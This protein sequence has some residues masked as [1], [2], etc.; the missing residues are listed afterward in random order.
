MHHALHLNIMKLKQEYRQPYL[1]PTEPPRP[2]GDLSSLMFTQSGKRQ[3][4]HN[5]RVQMTRFVQKTIRTG[6]AQYDTEWWRSCEEELMKR[7]QLEHM[8]KSEMRTRRERERVLSGWDGFSLPYFQWFYSSERVQQLLKRLILDI[9]SN[10]WTPIQLCHRFK[11]KCCKSS[12]HTPNCSNT[13]RKFLG[14]LYHNFAEEVEKAATRTVTQHKDEEGLTVST[15]LELDI[16]E[17]DI[18]S[19]NMLVA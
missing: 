8:V 3:R 11:T 16:S 1:S 6:K 10:P 18:G 12:S 7:V 14:F 19:F 13:W 9:Y 2:S 15:M 5:V 4:S 17:S